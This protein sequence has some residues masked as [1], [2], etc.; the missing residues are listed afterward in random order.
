[1]AMHN[2]MARILNHSDIKTEANT[3]ETNS[4]RRKML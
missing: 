1:M 2:V 4:K 3:K